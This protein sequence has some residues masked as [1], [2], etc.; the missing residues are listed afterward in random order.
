MLSRNVTFCIIASFGSAG[1]FISPH[2][3][4]PFASRLLYREHDDDSSQFAHTH[5]PSGPFGI[6]P[7]P[8]SMTEQDATRLEH[9]LPFSTFTAIEPEPL[10]SA[11]YP[12]Q[13]SSYCPSVDLPASATRKIDKNLAEL[14]EA[15]ELSVGRIA[16][17]SALI[18]FMDEILTGQSLPQQFLSVIGEQM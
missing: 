11:S 15:I 17:M 13:I 18:L 6:L 1:A 16:M 7:S 2:V 9:T 5:L 12:I 10:I 8:T 3:N 14:T 4:K